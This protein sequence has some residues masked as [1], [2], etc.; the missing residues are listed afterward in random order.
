MRIFA[1]GRT[2]IGQTA[3][4]QISVEEL[5]NRLLTRIRAAGTGHNIIDVVIIRNRAPKLAN[6]RIGDFASIGLRPVSKDCKDC[7]ANAE[8]ELQRDLDVIWTN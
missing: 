3:R 5:K 6:W 2:I 7:A 4:S 1:G 8:S